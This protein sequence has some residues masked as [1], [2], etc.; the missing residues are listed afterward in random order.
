MDQ[1]VIRGVPSLELGFEP[2]RWTFAAK[3][4]QAIAEN[5]SAQQVKKP[6]LFN[7]KVLL[8]RDPQ[9]DGDRL[10]G[11]YFESD[12]ATYLTWRDFGFP[13]DGIF[14]GFGMGAL[15]DPDGVY[16]MGEMSPH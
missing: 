15:R 3:N 12:F 11:R 6:E 5:F 9:V 13:G 10:T 16:V 4:A 7:G 2:W 8:M 14:S 1:V